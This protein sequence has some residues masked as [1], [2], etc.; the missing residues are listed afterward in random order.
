M[1]S[2][3]DAHRRDVHYEVG[4]WVYVKLKPYRQTSLAGKTP[5]KLAK[6]YFGPFQILN[7][8]GQMAYH[9]ALPDTSKIHLVFHCSS[10]KPHHGPPPPVACTLLS[11]NYNNGSLLSPLV[12]LGTRENISSDS[13]QLEVLVQCQG[14]SREQATWE[15][16]MNI[17]RTF[18]LENKVLL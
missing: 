13:P 15:P 16:W 12:I 10:L 11:N 5:Q 4:M 6:R 17:Q 1:K 14:A 18:N 7:R 8:I 2:M 3:V 9:L